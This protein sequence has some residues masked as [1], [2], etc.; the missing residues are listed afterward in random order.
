MQVKETKN[1]GLKRA[2]EIIIDAQT[3]ADNVTKKI[4]E[5]GVRF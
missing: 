3:I 4:K 2:F 5:I 1:D